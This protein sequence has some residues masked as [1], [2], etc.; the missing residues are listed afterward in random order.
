MRLFIDTSALVKKYIEEQGSN[1]VTELFSEA[2]VISVS[3]LTKIEA[4][5]TFSRIYR[6][7]S[8][9]PSDYSYLIKSLENDLEFFEC[10]DFDHAVQKIAIDLIQKRQLKSLDAIQLA[11]AFHTQQ[12]CDSFVSCDIKLLQVAQLEKF[13]VLNPV[14]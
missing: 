11:C 5:S 6:D 14:L 10:V 3:F 7:K 13:K 4:I 12:P 1:Q 2:E 9:S 8:I